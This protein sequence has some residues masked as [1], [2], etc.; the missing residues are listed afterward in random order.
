VEALDVN[1]PSF[2]S[3][4]EDIFNQFV[5]PKSKKEVNVS[6]ANRKLMCDKWSLYQAGECTNEDIHAEFIQ[7][8]RSFF[9]N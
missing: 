1:A 8:I 7:L 5:P 9:F 3:S 4:V 6:A 2:K